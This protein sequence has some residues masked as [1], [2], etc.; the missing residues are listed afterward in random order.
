MKLRIKKI[1]LGPMKEFNAFKT[2]TTRGGR[3]MNISPISPA[4]ECKEEL[5]QCR[6]CLEQFNPNE[7]DN[8]FLAPCK[9]SGSVKYVHY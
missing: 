3:G 8:P 1:Q 5:M 4:K 6:I 2:L 9:C 7:V